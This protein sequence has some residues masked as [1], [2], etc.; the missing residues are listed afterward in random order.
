MYVQPKVYDRVQRILGNIDVIFLGM[1]CQGAPLSCLYGPLLP[2]TLNR[3]HDQ[4]RRLSRSN[5]IQAKAL[6]DIFCPKDVFVY[7]MGM[8][9]WLEYISSIKYTE[10]SKPIIESNRLL[11]Y[12]KSK[13]IIGER[14]FGEKY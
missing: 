11:D 8:E 4:S 5:F 9:P 2:Q 6:I 3:E 7:T 12:C 13:G 1:E 10:E 14:L